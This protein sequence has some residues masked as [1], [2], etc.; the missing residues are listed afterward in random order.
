MAKPAHALDRAYVRCVLGG[1]AGGVGY[2]PKT[3]RSLAPSG[4]NQTDV[5]SVLET[6]SGTSIERENDDETIFNMVGSTCD[7]ERLQVKLSFKHDSDGLCV[8]DVA[9]L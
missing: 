4:L 3:L 1:F 2:S 5:L 8:I 6:S 9:R 7:G